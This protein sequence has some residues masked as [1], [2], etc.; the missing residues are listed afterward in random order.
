MFIDE[1]LN[2]QARA[3]FLA[4]Q[5]DM[6]RDLMR[7][8][9]VPS[10]SKPE[11]KDHPPFGKE[12]RRMAELFLSMAEEYGFETKNY[13]YYCARASIGAGEEIAFWSHLDV[14]EAGSGWRFDPFD[15][16][17]REGYIIGRGAQDNKGSAVCV[18][19]LMRFLKETGYPLRHKISLYAGFNEECGMAD[20]EYF[21]KTQKQP[22]LTIVADCAFPVCV[23]ERGTLEVRLLSRETPD[24]R[25]T[26]LS[27]GE[28]VSML[29][30]RAVLRCLDVTPQTCREEVTCVQENGETVF[31][32]HGT[33]DHAAMPGPAP[34]AL[35]LLA[36]AALRAGIGS[37]TGAFE[38]LRLAAADSLGEGLGIACSD[39]A[40]GALISGVT[41]AGLRDGHLWF[42]VS[43]RFPITKSSEEILG[44]LTDTAKRHG[45][46]VSVLRRQEPVNHEKLTPVVQG[47]TE[48]YNQVMGEKTRPF[49]MSGGTYARKLKNALPFGT[50]LPMPP[51]PAHL[52]APGHGDY[53]QADECIETARMQ[54]GCLVYAAS[55]FWLDTLDLAS[56]IYG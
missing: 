51:R 52:F 53:H 3:W 29:P 39:E 37:E 28:S 35:W 6:T 25:V 16:T 54:A 33:A 49:V 21:V 4:H 13:D 44:R 47:L 46:D 12:C 8:I 24:G 10:V 38:F 7:M 18:M 27:A 40:S 56:D 32:A 19:Y 20:A 1:T 5:P 11:E 45:C 36:D 31:T 15:A 14:V 2:E 41:T 30:E 26:G 50:G 43:V 9:A 22:P 17:E 42:T 48:V 34:N 55:V 23:G